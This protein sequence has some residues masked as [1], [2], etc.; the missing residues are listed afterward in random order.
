LLPRC[1]AGRK[2]YKRKHVAGSVRAQ[3]EEGKE[4]GER[5]AGQ[6]SPIK[7]E[8]EVQFFFF[9]RAQREFF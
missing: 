6:L 5:L 2:E 8:Q 7:L 4:R 1:L 3:Q 9:M